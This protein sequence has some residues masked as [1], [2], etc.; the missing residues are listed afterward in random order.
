MKYSRKRT[1]FFVML[2]DLVLLIVSVW[3]ALSIRSLRLPSRAAFFLHL[4][5]FAP[6]I[7]ADIVFIYL[8]NLYSLNSVFSLRKLSIRFALIA[9]VGFFLGVLFFYLD[10][11]F[12]ITPKTILLLFSAISY[13]L[14]VLWRLLFSVMGRS[15][16]S[17]FG[18]VFIGRSPSVSN[19]VRELKA[20]A[21]LGF[22]PLLVYCPD[23]NDCGDSGVEATSDLN[24]VNACLERH[25]K[26]VFVYCRDHGFPPS[27]EKFIFSELSVG[28]VFY[29]LPDF[30]EMITRT[31]PLEEITQTWF[32]SHIDI[33]SKKTFFVLKRLFD[34]LL[35]ASGLLL[36]AIFWPLIVILIKLESDGPAFYAQT[37][38][39]YLGCEFTIYKFRTMRT[40]NNPSGPTVEHD[41]RI[42]RIGNI[43]R[44]SR[45]DELPQL[46]NVLKGDM[47]IIGPRP[48][49]PE[50]A[51]ELELSVPYYRQRLMVKPGITGWDQVSGEYHSPSVEDTY[52]KLQRDL[53]YIKN[54]SISLDISIVFKTVLTVLSRSGR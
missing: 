18:V 6:V 38:E 51:K 11:S 36:S 42:T 16:R 46:L 49:R 52:K 1:Q 30:Y 37:R 8:V 45:I 3:V 19:L 23:A 22:D 15:L 41:R 12:A 35:S 20:N 9:V 40:D 25:P 17:R 7:L 4:R 44:K 48:E 54:I 34:V 29:S 32:L 43:L 53:Y 33:G 5:A 47:S 39:G 27:I 10:T 24:A 2:V 21:A 31:V 14:L 13:G 28:R 50:L 26:T